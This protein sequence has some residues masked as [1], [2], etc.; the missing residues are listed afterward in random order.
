MKKL[1]KLAAKAVNSIIGIETYGWPPVCFGVIY[2]PSRP[3]KKP[4]GK[5]KISN[6]AEK[7]E[8][9]VAENNYHRPDI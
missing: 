3:E 4:C 2:Q 5:N 1:E 6:N 7:N 9:I 8:L